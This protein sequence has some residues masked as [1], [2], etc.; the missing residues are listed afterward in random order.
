MTTLPDRDLLIS[1]S[2][3]GAVASDWSS[4]LGMWAEIAGALAVCAG[5]RGCVVSS[6]SS[7]CGA[8]LFGFPVSACLS[9]V[10]ANV[11]GGNDACASSPGSYCSC[12]PSSG[13]GERAV[14]AV[15]LPGDAVGVLLGRGNMADLG[16][17]DAG[18]GLSVAGG[19]DSPRER[20]CGVVAGE[21]KYCGAVLFCWGCAAAGY[22]Y[23][24]INLVDAT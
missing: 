10:D 4:L 13:I 11:P 6:G 5:E 16:E 23:F 14:S 1:T 15:F 19:G 21:W 2:G 17:S 20:L 22:A 18:E 3:S 7:C 9:G 24:F 12:P 8:E